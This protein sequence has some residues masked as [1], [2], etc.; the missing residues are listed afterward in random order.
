MFCER[1]VGIWHNHNRTW[2]LIYVKNPQVLNAPISYQ[3]WGFKSE[4]I[5][6]WIEKILFIFQVVLFIKIFSFLLVLGKFARFLFYI[7]NKMVKA[8]FSD[9]TSETVTGY[10]CFIEEYC[11][12]IT[13]FSGYIIQYYLYYSKLLI[14]EMLHFIY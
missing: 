13:S 5:R 1:I 11:F 14:S 3:F 9:V 12:Q 4:W 6:F 8:S 7:Y 10:R 2:S